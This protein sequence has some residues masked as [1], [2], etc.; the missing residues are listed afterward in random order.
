MEKFYVYVLNLLMLVCFASCKE[1]RQEQVIRL[2]NEWD[3]K[4]IRFPSHSVFTVLGQDTVDSFDEKGTYRIIS[5][6]DSVGCMSCK[7]QLPKW[8][9]LIRET[10]SLLGE[11]LTYRFYFHPKDLKDLK[12]VLR[13]DRFN[14]PVCIDLQDAFN[15][16]NRFPSEM[17]FQTFL[18]D[19]LNRVVAI[20]NP[21]HN[22]KVKE[23]YLSVLTGKKHDVS[24]MMKT[25]VELDKTVAD[26]GDVPWKEAQRAVFELKNTG[27][28][29]LVIYDVD[30]SCGCVD[31]E[32]S[33]EPLKPG[34]TLA[35]TVTYTAE[36]P[37]QINKTISLHCNVENSPVRLQIKGNARE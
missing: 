14:Y 37:E 29:L 16:L 2:V 33:K 30:T 34:K 21:V 32:Y 22:A 10:D 19:S 28:N 12:Y 3:G 8:K 9:E 6:V 24:S 36:H 31:V 17:T 27:E 15:R 26:L 25:S 1:S 20:G 35:V 4:V 23:L 13:R 7:L 18:L 5:Y 11:R